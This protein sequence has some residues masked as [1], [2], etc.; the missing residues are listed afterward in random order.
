LWAVIF[1]RVR[2]AFAALF[3]PRWQAQEFE[4]GRHRKTAP[5]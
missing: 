3:Q 1:V 2:P 4:E 5:C